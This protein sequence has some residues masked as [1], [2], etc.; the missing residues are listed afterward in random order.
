MKRAH[1][2]NELASPGVVADQFDRRLD[3]FGP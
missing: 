3:R 2:R 1:E